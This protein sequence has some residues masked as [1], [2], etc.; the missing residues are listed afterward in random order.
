[1]TECPSQ[2]EFMRP[3]EIAECCEGVSDDLYN[4]LWVLTAM[5]EG[6]TPEEAEEPIH[7]QNALPKFWSALTPEHQQ[8]LVSIAKGMKGW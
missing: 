6:P 3:D 7:G 1:M 2:F 8:E 5:Y 4:G